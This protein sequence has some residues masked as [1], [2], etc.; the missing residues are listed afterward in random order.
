MTFVYY[1]INL[2]HIMSKIFP[3]LDKLIGQY[4][5]FNLSR[6]K[7]LSQLIICMIS[8]KTVNLSSISQA[9]KT[10]ATPD[11]NYKRLQRLI[12]HIYISRESLAKLIVAIKGLDSQKSWKLTMDWTNWKF[13]KTHINILYLGVCCNN[14]AIPLFSHF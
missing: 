2:K 11:S 6:I 14:V 7:C 10:N 8:Q 12:K 3:I 5:G 4:F 1:I 9:M 13:G